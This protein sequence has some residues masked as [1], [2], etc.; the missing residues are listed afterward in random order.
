MTNRQRI[1][2]LL[3]ILL[4]A[5]SVRL[6]LIYRSRH[7]AAANNPQQS[8]QLD[9]DAYIVPKK[10]HAYNLASLH[11][12]AGKPVWIQGGYQIT[13]YPYDPHTKRSDF[14]HE[15]GVLGPIEEVQIKDVVKN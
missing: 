12:L 13:Y 2:L 4:V 3:L 11:A 5:A 6:L 8:T 7:Q 15:A 1:Q 10:L 9:T 14:K